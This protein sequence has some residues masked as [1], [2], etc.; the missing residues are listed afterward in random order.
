MKINNNKLDG[1]D[2][3]KIEVTNLDDGVEHIIKTILEQQ[4]PVIIS[5]IGAAGSG[6]AKLSKRIVDQIY[7][8]H[9]KRGWVGHSDTIANMKQEYITEESKIYNPDYI[10]VKG[11]LPGEVDD[12]ARETFGKAPDLRVCMTKKFVP[13]NLRRKNVMHMTAIEQLERG[14]YGLIIENPAEDK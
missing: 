14:Y 12:F 2:F 10:L 13:E 9:K 6:K 11:F 3:N 5:V 1:W 8:Q 7:L 4:E